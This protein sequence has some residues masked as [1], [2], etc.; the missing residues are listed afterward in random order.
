MVCHVVFK[1]LTATLTSM[2]QLIDIDRLASRDSPEP[3]SET[4]MAQSPVSSLTLFTGRINNVPMSTAPPGRK[5]R[6]RTR[7]GEP[8]FR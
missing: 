2:L 4:I 8:P 5:Q 6:H 1:M 3:P 7:T